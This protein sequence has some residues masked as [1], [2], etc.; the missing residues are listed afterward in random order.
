MDRFDIIEMLEGRYVPSPK[1]DC[2][3]VVDGKY[4]DFSLLNYLPGILEAMLKQS[5]SQEDIDRETAER[6][7]YLYTT[8]PPKFGIKPEQESYL[9]FEVIGNRTNLTDGELWQL[10]VHGKRPTF[11]LE[12]AYP[13]TKNEQEALDWFQSLEPDEVLAQLEFRYQDWYNE[14][15]QALQMAMGD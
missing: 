6:L 8:S 10:I 1:G 11:N 2:H 12:V 15:Q 13:T 9:W 7:T 5:I 3:K 14:Q 4:G